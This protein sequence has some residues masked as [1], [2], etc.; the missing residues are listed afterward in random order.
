MR[1]T[2][3]ER[4]MRRFAAAGTRQDLATLRGLLALAPGPDHIKRLMAGFEAAY[5]GR[6][7]A[8]LPAEL[9]DALA[10][11]SGQSV[12]IG[13]RQGKPD[14]STEALR[15]AGRRPGRSHQAAPA[16]AGPGRGAPAGLRSGRAPAGVPV[17]RQRLAD[18]RLELP[19]PA[20]TTLPSPLQ[21]SKLIPTCPTTCWLPPR[22]C[23]RRDAP[24]RPSSS[25]R[26]RL[27]RSILT[28][29][30]ARSSRGCCC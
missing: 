24:G 26:S 29:F 6:S 7:L 19:W 28:P 3:A 22:A 20:T 12:T 17:V 13:L 1:A 21:S 18:G 2:I 23:S 4:L 15:L 9:A 8:G 11:Y 30:H 10:Q 27:M 25:R 16:P 14:A 5:A